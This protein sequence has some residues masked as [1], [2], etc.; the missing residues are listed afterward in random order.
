MLP[1]RMPSSHPVRWLIGLATTAL[2]PACVPFAPGLIPPGD[3][4]RLA[5]DLADPRRA[6]NMAKLG[7]Q[8]ANKGLPGQGSSLLPTHPGLSPS[9]SLPSAPGSPMFPGVAP[10]NPFLP[11]PSPISFAAIP[12]NASLPDMVGVPGSGVNLRAT[13]GGNILR[14]AKPGEVFHVVDTQ[15]HWINAQTSSG[16]TAWIHR[17]VVKA[18]QFSRLPDVASPP[19]SLTQSAASPTFAKI[20]KAIPSKSFSPLPPTD[21]LPAYVGT[22]NP[23]TA[24]FARPDGSAVRKSTRGEVF[25]TLLVRGDWVLV[26]PHS[27]QPAWVQRAHL[28]NPGIEASPVTIYQT[29]TPIAPAQASQSQSLSLTGD[30]QPQSSSQGIDA[31]KVGEVIGTLG[32]IWLK[33]RQGAN[34]ANAAVE[35]LILEGQ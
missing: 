12:Q 24:L 1:L 4:L 6:G 7:M 9:A 26:Q 19:E 3:A 21:S 27:G 10:S 15:G 25:E 8:L 2:L 20:P 17:S 29:A 14:T 31:H 5:T 11:A 22:P 33:I 32:R 13:P 34:P 16:E 28:A 30:G 23:G 18:P 35:T